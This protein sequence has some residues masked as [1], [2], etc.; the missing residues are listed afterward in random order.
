MKDHMNIHLWIFCVKNL[1]EHSNYNV[2]AFNYIELNVFSINICLHLQVVSNATSA[3]HLI[4][5]T[6]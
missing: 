5:L 1:G 2:V 3:T 6:L 4:A